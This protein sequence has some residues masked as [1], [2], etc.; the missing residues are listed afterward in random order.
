[1]NNAIL[2]YNKT[3][4]DCSKIIT[5]NYSTSFSLGIRSLS[6]NI[7]AHIYAIYGFV[8]FADEIVDTFH[9]HDKETILAIFKKNTEDAI[10]KKFSTNPVLHSFQIVVNTYNIDKELID[11]FL[12]SIGLNLRRDQ[13]EN[14]HNYINKIN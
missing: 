1:M 10:K 13:L 12:K 5:K 4:L 9:H 14:M 8:R 2:L 3:A 6:K 11:A 7:H